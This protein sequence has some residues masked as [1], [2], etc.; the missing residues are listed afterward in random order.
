VGS[1]L[2]STLGRLLSGEEPVPAIWLAFAAGL[3]LRLVFALLEPRTHL[4]GDERAWV[5]FGRNWVAGAGFD[6]LRSRILFYPPLYTYLL[7]AV[8]AFLGGLAAVK[9]A[10]ILAGALLV[11]AVGLAGLRLFAPRAAV[12]AA[13]L[14][15]FY[16]VLVWFSV[17]YW[18]EPLFMVLL[19]WS[20]ERLLHAD[21]EG[22][23]AWALA[24]GL[25]L[26]LAAL[27]RETALYFAPLAAVAWGWVAGRARESGRASSCWARSSSWARGRRGTGSC[28]TPSCPS[29]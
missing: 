23:G 22:R 9:L 21:A 12:L 2:K 3:A 5:D 14:V 20:I 17:H 15:A 4:V 25:L 6:P 27:T 1:R 8:D 26:G 24:A 28:S 18:S 11:P 19:W 29:R 13:F 7:G 16:P 10:Q